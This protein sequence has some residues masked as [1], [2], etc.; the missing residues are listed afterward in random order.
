MLQLQAGKLPFPDDN[1]RVIQLQPQG[2]APEQPANTHFPL[3]TTTHSIDAPKSADS[4]LDEVSISLANACLHTFRLRML[5]H[6]PFIDIPHLTT[7]DQLQR[8][9]PY[10]L[11][12]IVCVASPTARERRSRAIKL[13]RV[14]CE[15]AFLQESVEQNAEDRTVDLLLAILTYAA[16]G[17]DYLHGSGTSSL[18]RLVMLAMSLVG[19]MRLDKPPPPDIHTLTLFTP[20][21]LS[22]DS[23]SP[24]SG[25]AST[26][27]FLE[28]QRAVLACYVLTSAVSAYFGHVDGL[29]WTPEMDESLVAISTNRD[30]PT[31]GILSMQV[32]LQLL[33]AE[34]RRNR[35]SQQQHNNP[36]LT[37]SQAETLLGQLQEIRGRFRS[38]GVEQHKDVLAQMADTE[39]CILESVYPASSTGTPVTTCT[40]VSSNVS[41]GSGSHS[42]PGAGSSGGPL[43]FL[44]QSLLAIESCTS[45]LL[46][47]SPVDFLG[48]S[49]V[50]WAQVT[51]SVVIL[52]H[53]DAVQDPSWDL[54]A[55]RGVVDL[56]IMLDQLTGKLKR[57]AAESGEQNPGDVFTQ[58]ATGIHKFRAGMRVAHDRDEGNEDF[59]M[60]LEAQAEDSNGINRNTTGSVT[61]T[62]PQRGHFR[63]PRFWLDQIF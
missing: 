3:Q 27:H 60:D 16:W 9:R 29:R 42:S 19:E 61:Q 45:S 23:S 13:K 43:A 24:G 55:V 62:G 63:N 44:W 32:R 41:T 10:L 57:A 7:V 52:H 11:R 5:P 33:A 8:D 53:L 34:A 54:S 12:A 20:L 48:I 59:E 56:P 21:G 17:W 1:D 35:A 31:D 50:Q 58:L 49:F 22:V 2:T 26:H 40:P 25:P 39:L 18:S 38:S 6:F 15:A 47:L 30:C 14:L 46:A 28:R 4:E 36:I 51:H 37:Q